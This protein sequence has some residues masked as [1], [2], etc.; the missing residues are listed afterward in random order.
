M[1]ST[2][3]TLDCALPLAHPPTDPLDQQQHQL[4]V[5]QTHFDTVLEEKRLLQRSLADCRHELLRSFEDKEALAQELFVAKQLEPPPTIPSSQVMQ[6]LQSKEKL[7]RE[8][9]GKGVQLQVSPCDHLYEAKDR[10][11]GEVV[12][13]VASGGGGQDFSES[14]IFFVHL[15]YPKPLFRVSHCIPELCSVSPTVSQP[16]CVVSFPT[17][18]AH[19]MKQMSLKSMI[20]SGATNNRGGAIAAAMLTRAVVCAAC[21]QSLM[22]FHTNLMRN[23]VDSRRST[24]RPVFAGSSV[25]LLVATRRSTG[26]GKSQMARSDGLH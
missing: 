6:A 11:S 20:S 19:V 5:L 8:L 15:V 9:G 2:L 25:Y 4:K 1:A 7:E 13:W 18:M 16:F 26:V 23:A 10:G 3:K 12:V 14:K 22:P 17:V 24:E 21:F